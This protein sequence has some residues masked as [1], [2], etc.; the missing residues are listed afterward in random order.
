VGGAQLG[1]EA[2]GAALRT[3]V[4]ATV[5]SG[6]SDRSVAEPSNNTPSWALKVQ[7]RKRPTSTD[8]MPWE[9]L[10]KRWKALHVASY[11]TFSA[12]FEAGGH[13]FWLVTGFDKVM[14]QQTL[15][16]V[17]PRLSLTVAALLL[18]LLAFVHNRKKS[19]W[20]AA[21]IA[22]WCV[23][24]AVWISRWVYGYP[25]VGRGLTVMAA[26]MAVFGLYG[27]IR[28]RRFDRA[29]PPLDPSR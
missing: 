4:G 11:P 20:T 7:D 19:V 22:V 3:S 8:I 16:P 10:D 17:T 27:T 12:G 15:L 21:I 6:A 9:R 1:G 13:A 24:S 26:L 25:G 29:K 28:L 2:D 18:T 5:R 14:N 23:C